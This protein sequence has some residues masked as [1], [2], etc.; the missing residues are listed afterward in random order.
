MN[1]RKKKVFWTMEEKLAR[2]K[3]MEQLHPG[4]FAEKERTFVLL[5]AAVFL[6]GVYYAMT[7]IINRTPLV[8]GLFMFLG[9]FIL[10]CV[11]MVASR[12]RLIAGCL[13]GMRILEL[14][15][16]LAQTLPALFYFSFL[17][18]IW[19]VTMMF[20]FDLDLY[21]LGQ[22]LFHKKAIMQTKYYQLLD[23]PEE[24]PVPEKPAQQETDTKTAESENRE[25]SEETMQR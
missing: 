24:L 11:Y 22:P 21:Y 19:W 25:S 4:Y 1:S 13:F 14:A 9:L 20:E 15:R 7:M 23:S 18:K 6:R 10:S 16:I 2:E 12:S 5:G 17:F 8:Y 3:Q